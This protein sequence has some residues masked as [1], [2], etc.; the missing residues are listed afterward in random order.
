[1]FILTET[2]TVSDVNEFQT[3][4]IGLCQCDTHHN[5]LDPA[6]K[7][8]SIVFGNGI[9]YDAFDQINVHHTTI[10]D[11]ILFS[12]YFEIVIHKVQ[13]VADFL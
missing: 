2:H 10:V 4:F 1:M 3:H 6:S 12:F 5:Y 11:N 13:H 8:I 7:S 9:N